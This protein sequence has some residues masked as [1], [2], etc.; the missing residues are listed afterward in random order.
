MRV[1]IG[2]DPG[3]GGAAAGLNVD[4]G[5]VVFLADTP[6]VSLGGRRDYALREMVELLRP[7]RDR[8]DTMLVGLEY[9]HA[10]PKMSAV[11]S[12]GIGRG[13]GLWEAVL[14]ALG[15]PYELVPTKAWAGV[16]V[17]GSS[18]TRAASPLS[19]NRVARDKGKSLLVARR[20]WPEAAL[21]LAKHHNRA[22]ALLIAEYLR[23]KTIAVGP[24]TV[25]GADN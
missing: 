23:R 3:I 13:M 21:P 12:F 8:A 19:G 20:L 14:V 16:M 7:S 24:R 10:M 17:P 1:I 5:A 22:E 9:V 4:S 25:Y 6:S 11:A 15:L 18:G 2:I